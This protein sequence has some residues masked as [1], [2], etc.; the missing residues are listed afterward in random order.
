VRRPRQRP[1]TGSLILPSWCWRAAREADP[2][3]MSGSPNLAHSTSGA[4]ASKSG[5]DPLRSALCAGPHHV[6]HSESSGLHDQD[7]PS[8]GRHGPAPIAGGGRNPPA[9]ALSGRLSRCWRPDRGPPGERDRRLANRLN[10][11][12]PVKW[13][14][15]GFGWARTDAVSGTTSRHGGAESGGPSPE[16]LNG[17]QLKKVP[18]Q[19]LGRR[20]QTAR[21]PEARPPPDVG[22]VLDSDDFG[23][24][25][26]VGG[27]SGSHGWAS[28]GH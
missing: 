28:G 27:R 4:A 7:Y 25:G 20:R 26:P 24:G 12:R 18:P 14:C 10:G 1:Q 2:S 6:R 23:R 5:A 19:P 13:V 9:R 21:E 17:S 22:G 16:L 11:T 8:E 3:R 15:N